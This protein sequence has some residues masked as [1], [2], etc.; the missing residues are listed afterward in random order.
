MPNYCITIEYDGSAFAGWQLQ[1]EQ[2]TIHGELESAL[3]MLNRGKPTRI[4]GAGRTDTGVHARGQV[5]NF[6]IDQKWDEEELRR[7]INGNVG[8]D[9]YIHKCQ[10]V[11]DDFHARFSARSRRYSYRCRINNAILDRNYVWR[12]GWL[13]AVEIL[14]ACADIV[15]GE[16]DFTSFSKWSSG[17]KNRSCIVQQSRWINDG[18][19]VTYTIEANH[20]L[21]HMI[22]Y[23]VGTMIEVA[24]EKISVEDFQ[25]LLE[26]R[27]P[28]ARIYKAPAEGLILE[29]V[30]Y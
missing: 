18:D 15:K 14:Q 28:Q 6:I 25:I 5:A 22:R 10:K 13:P 3:A 11:D 24:N 12:L 30:N 20:F 17:V 2:R 7:A 16:H 21:Q 4:H 19:F 23:L 1:P 8:R 29:E 27:N 26:E 9:V